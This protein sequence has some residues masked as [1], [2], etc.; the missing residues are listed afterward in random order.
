[1][2]ESWLIFFL[3]VWDLEATSEFECH[4]KEYIYDEQEEFIISN[5]LLFLLHVAMLIRSRDTHKKPIIEWIDSLWRVE[6]EIYFTLNNHD[7]N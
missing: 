6:D 3:I 4:E 5:L 2:W 7:E 1:M